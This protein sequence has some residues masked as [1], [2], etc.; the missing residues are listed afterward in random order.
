M[1]TTIIAL[2]RKFDQPI[3]I[4]VPAGAAAQATLSIISRP[5]IGELQDFEDVDLLYQ[6]ALPDGHRIRPADWRYLAYDH[7]AIKRLMAET[8]Y[9]NSRQLIFEPLEEP[10][11]RQFEEILHVAFRDVA[12]V[13]EAKTITCDARGEEVQ[14]TVSGEHRNGSSS[15]YVFSIPWIP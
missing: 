8:A 10:L 5:I 9:Q 11:F 3:E 7:R 6:V 2:L 4:D 14:A 15:T 13:F 1:T 12:H